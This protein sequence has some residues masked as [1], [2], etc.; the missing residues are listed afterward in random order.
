[1]LASGHG[2]ASRAGRAIGPAHRSNDIDANPFISEVS[3][4]IYKGFE[5]ILHGKDRIAK[6][7]SLVK[8]IIA[9]SD[10]SGER[11]CCPLCKH[12]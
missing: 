3:D 4:C 8:Y 9:E 7:L 5:I 1:V 11:K 6:I 10:R 2:G 12:I